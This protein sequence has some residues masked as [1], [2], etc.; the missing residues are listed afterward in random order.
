MFIR[1]RFG[2]MDLLLCWLRISL[3]VSHVFCN[4]VF[5]FIKFYKVKF[6]FR[7]SY[8]PFKYTVIYASKFILQFSFSIQFCFLD[9]NFLYSLSLNFIDCKISFVIHL[10]I[11][12]LF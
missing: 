1:N 6:S 10:L 9:N 5:M 4:A 7:F 8:I 2:N 3:I 11:L 12:C